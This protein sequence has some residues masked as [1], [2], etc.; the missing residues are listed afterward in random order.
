VTGSVVVVPRVVV[1]ATDGRR[2]VVGGSAV[3][4]GAEVVADDGLMVVTLADGRVDEVRGGIGVV[5]CPAAV[6]VAFDRGVPGRVVVKLGAR[7]V[8]GEV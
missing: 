8:V 7:V 3:R 6:V 4:V 1:G 5:G 2:L